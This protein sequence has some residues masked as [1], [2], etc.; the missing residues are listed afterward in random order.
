VTESE[1]W[2]LTR[3]RTWGG[4]GRALKAQFPLF[5]YLTLLMALMNMCSHG[6]QDL[7]PAF[8]QRA[9]GFGPGT[10][11][12]L[13]ALSM[14]GALAGGILIGQWSNRFGRRRAIVVALFAAVVVIPL[15]A[16]APS[17]ALLVLGA[18]LMQFLVQGAWG[19]IPAHITELAP[20]QVR[21]ALPGFA[22]QCGALIAGVMPYAQAKVAGT[23]GYPATMA[24]SAGTAF[25]VCA[26]IAGLGRERRG[27]V[28]GG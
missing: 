5:C 13:T 10:R 27:V 3:E 2:L 22:Y 24:L 20:D 12:A 18:V 16:F 28:Y 23:L 17:L 1:V 9:W 19:V 8:L 26:L 15:W 7:Y 14:A 4:L 11:S 6:T 21:G 25:V